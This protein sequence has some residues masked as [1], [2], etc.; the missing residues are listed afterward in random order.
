[1]SVLARCYVGVAISYASRISIDGRCG[2]S[3]SMGLRGQLMRMLRQP[4][5]GYKAASRDWEAVVSCLR[6]EY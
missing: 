3:V 1:V 6:I 2:C 4:F 5:V